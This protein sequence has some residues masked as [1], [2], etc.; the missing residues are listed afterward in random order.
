MGPQYDIFLLLFLHCFPFFIHL[1]QKKLL[2]NIEKNQILPI[3]L[4]TKGYRNLSFFPKNTLNKS[5]AL[6]KCI[7]LSQDSEGPSVPYAL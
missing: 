1:K 3:L 2:S 5:D 6:R 4:V 7:T